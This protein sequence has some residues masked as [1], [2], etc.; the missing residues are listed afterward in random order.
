MA[1][2]RDRVTK[3]LAAF[4][5]GRVV[6]FARFAIRFR[7]ATFA[8]FLAVAIITIGMLRGGIVRFI[9]FPQIEGDR[10][11]ISL[12]M[13]QGTPFTVTEGTIET[14]ETAVYAVRD[15]IEAEA[16]HPAFESVSVSIGTVAGQSGGP[17]GGGGGGSGAHL[18]EL[19][20]QLLPSDF[21]SYTA[22]EIEAKI[23]EVTAS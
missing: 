12:T 15:E 5:N 10:I 16:G 13:P 14:I 1:T 4:V 23:L 2:M 17:G 6:P 22:S 20:I 3:L 18:G 7:Y 21:R 11:N 9:F 19:R 8:V